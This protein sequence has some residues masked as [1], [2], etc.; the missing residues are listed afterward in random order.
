ME[1]PKTRREAFD[2][3]LVHFFNGKPCKRGHVS[4]RYVSS[5]ACVACLDFSKH[6]PRGINVRQMPRPV[7]FPPIKAGESPALFDRAL[8]ILEGW[9]PQAL[10]AAQAELVKP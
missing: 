10:A 6:G 7:I 1:L 4:P 3:K 5:G 2:A 8:V 9:A